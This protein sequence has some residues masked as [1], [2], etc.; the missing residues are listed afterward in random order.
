MGLTAILAILL[1]VYRCGTPHN[2]NIVRCVCAGFSNPN[3]SVSAVLGNN[4]AGQTS[5]FHFLAWRL[6]PVCSPVPE[7]FVSQLTRPSAMRHTGS[8]S[9][10]SRPS[11]TGVV[12][13]NASPIFSSSPASSS[14]SATRTYTSYARSVAR[15]L[16]QAMSTAAASSSGPSSS[17]GMPRHGTSNIQRG[18]SSGCI[19]PFPHGPARHHQGRGRFLTH[20]TTG[21]PRPRAMA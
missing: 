5:S 3:T 7:Y 19:R 2:Y 12:S 17:K 9:D 11:V 6:S 21:I 13:A 14:S 4:L 1:S 18:I 15:G 16:L 20:R 8:Y 10:S